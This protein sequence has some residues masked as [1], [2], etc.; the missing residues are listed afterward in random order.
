MLLSIIS[1]ISGI[2]R[3]IFIFVALV[4]DKNN[5]SAYIALNIINRQ[6]RIELKLGKN[7]DMIS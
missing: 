7:E 3:F 4:D 5:L 1:A 2:L 6:K